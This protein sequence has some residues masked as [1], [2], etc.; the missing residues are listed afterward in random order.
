MPGV[1][2]AGFDLVVDAIDSLSSKVALILTA[3]ELG[4]P[5]VASMG[6]GGRLDPARVRV[7]DLMDTREC[8][9]ARALRTRLR[10]RGVG[11]GIRVVWSDEPPRPPLAPQAVGRGRARAVNGTVSYMPAIF[12]LTLA[13]LGVQQL[14]TTA[15]DR[16][17]CPARPGDGSAAPAAGSSPRP[18]GA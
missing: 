1:L 4:L 3:R 14:L 2:G 5:I 8:G 10:R 16:P 9:L 6:A 18:E 7:G 17:A 13:G 15:D 11:R 12:G